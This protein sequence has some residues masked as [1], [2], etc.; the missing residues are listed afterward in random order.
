MKK[1]FFYVLGM[2]ALLSS[3][4]SGSVEEIE[5]RMVSTG[6]VEKF[7]DATLSVAYYDFKEDDP[8][9][10]LSG[11][12]VNESFGRWTDEETSTI[13]IGDIVPNS[14]LTAKINI[15][16]STP[17]GEATK[18]DAYANDK[19]ISSGESWP[20]IIYLNIP[21]DIVG[22]SDTLSLEF[23]FKN[24]KR[25][26]DVDPEKK[27]TRLLG[28]GISC[29]TLYGVSVVESEEEEDED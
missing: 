18:Y 5:N 16:M 2:T 7:G 17:A 25:P 11:F 6:Y 4:G 22:D 14:D 8:K 27:D 9:C 29:V 20:G 23:K 26:I 3:C 13:T 21:S 28:M 24:A 10:E 1:T 15:T 19:L 12:S